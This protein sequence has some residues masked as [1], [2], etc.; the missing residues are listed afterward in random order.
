MQEPGVD[1]PQEE[2]EECHLGDPVE[3]GRD[4]HGVWIELG[5]VGRGQGYYGSTLELSSFGVCHLTPLLPGSGNN[6]GHPL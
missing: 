1:I 5:G 2:D 6:E 3:L 4:Q